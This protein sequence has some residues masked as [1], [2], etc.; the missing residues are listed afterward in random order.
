MRRKLRSVW[1]APRASQLEQAR[2]QRWY[3]TE[4]NSAHLRAPET[5][6]QS[7]TAPSRTVSGDL[8]TRRSRVQIPPPLLLM[9]LDQAPSRSGGRLSLAA[10]Q[11]RVKP[12]RP[13]RAGKDGPNCDPTRRVRQR[14]S[15]GDARVSQA[16]FDGDLEPRTIRPGERRSSPDAITEEVPRRTPREAFGSSS[17]RA[18]RSRTWRVISASNTSRCASGSAKPRPTAASCLGG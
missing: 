5:A 11:T 16:G 3:R 17:S 8:I 15:C 18:D 9:W 4:R 7:L 2:Y 13:A 1:A 10:C 12:A 14:A 6:A